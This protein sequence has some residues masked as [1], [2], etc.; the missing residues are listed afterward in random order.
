MATLIKTDK[1]REEVIKE[2]WTLKDIY[3]LCGGVA[4]PFPIGRGEVLYS[5]IDARLPINFEATNLLIKRV[6]GFGSNALTGNCLLMKLS[7]E[8]ES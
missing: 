3:E 7:E 4:L 5:T 2:R 6:Y 8:P 1:T